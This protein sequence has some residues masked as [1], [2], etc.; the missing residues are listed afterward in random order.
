MYT[1]NNSR[2]RA[3]TEKFSKNRKY[4]R[5]TL[6]DP[7]IQPDSL[8]GSRTC[9]HLTNDFCCTFYDVFVF[10]GKYHLMAS[11]ALG[12]AR[13]SVRHLLTKN[14]PVPTLAFRAGA[15]LN[16]L[17]HNLYRSIDIDYVFE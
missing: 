8:P 9:D 4:P 7:R 3:T 11:L 12:E 16:P 1:G 14:H 6:P 2:L 10:E 13:G 17:L 5:N 15:P